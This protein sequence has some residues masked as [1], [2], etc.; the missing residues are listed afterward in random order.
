VREGDAFYAA[1]ARQILLQAEELIDQQF[2]R[3]CVALSDPQLVRVFLKIHLGR[4][5]HEVFAVLFLDSSHRLIEYVELFRGTIDTAQVHPREVIKEAL[6][7]NAAAVIF[8]HNHPSGVAQPSK[9]DQRI[10]MQLKE[11]LDLVGVKVLDHV[12]VGESVTSF[13]ELGLL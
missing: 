10:T 11:A 8:A 13:V 12:I 3:Q 2:H 7:R 9:A 1:P 5:A 4:H 6:V